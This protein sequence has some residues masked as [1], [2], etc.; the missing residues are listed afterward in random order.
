MWIFLALFLCFPVLLIA[1]NG[2]YVASKPDRTLVQR[3]SSWLF[4]GLVTGLVIVT[5]IL[6]KVFLWYEE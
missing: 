3:D 5:S 2:T 1:R 4:L 6:I